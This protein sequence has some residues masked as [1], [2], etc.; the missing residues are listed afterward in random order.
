MSM[1]GRHGH[2]SKNARSSNNGHSVRRD[3]AGSDGSGVPCW[4]SGYGPSVNPGD[5]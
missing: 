1:P 2:N 3:M 5:A 4:Y